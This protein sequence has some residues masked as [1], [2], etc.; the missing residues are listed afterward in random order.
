MKHNQT[1][2]TL[3]LL[4]AFFAAQAEEKKIYK[5][6]DENGV[7]HYTETKPNDDYE[8]AD[9]PPLSIIPSAPIKAP[10]ISKAGASDEDVDPT[11]VQEFKLVQPVNEQ[12]LWGTGGKLTAQVTAL[13]PAQQEKYQI[14]FIIDGK[15]NKAADGSTQVFGDIYRGEHKVKALLVNRFNQ[16]VINETQTVTFFMHQNSVK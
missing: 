12:N 6:T 1:L 14:Q 2:L 10:T 15:K 3:G 8:E 9:L 4:A 5:W 7:T 13:T 11:V 16:K